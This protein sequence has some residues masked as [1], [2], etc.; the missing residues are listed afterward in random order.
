MNL[1][2]SAMV[3]TNSFAIFMWM[4][5]PKLLLSEKQFDPFTLQSNP[6][7]APTLTKFMF[8]EVELEELLINYN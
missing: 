2:D 8:R 7:I 3:L 6:F 4:N 1:L 5:K